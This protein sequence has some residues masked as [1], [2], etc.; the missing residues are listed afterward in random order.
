MTDLT[1]DPRLFDA[2]GKPLFKDPVF[3]S[4]GSPLAEIVEGTGWKPG[5]EKILDDFVYRR[6]VRDGSPG[7][8][9]QAVF[10]GKQKK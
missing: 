9:D 6:I 4:G 7:T 10:C 1:A 2:T 5:V 8:A 3:L